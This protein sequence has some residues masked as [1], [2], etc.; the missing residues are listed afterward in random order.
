VFHPRNS[1]PTGYL[2]TN[3]AQRCP[4]GRRTVGRIFTNSVE[5]GPDLAQTPP[6]SG[7]N[8]TRNVL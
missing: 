7:V 3:F 1:V 8:A 6:S 4:S 2:A 5:V